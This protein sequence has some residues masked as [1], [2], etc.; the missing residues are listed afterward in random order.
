L[1]LTPLPAQWAVEQVLSATIMME[2]LDRFS[3]HSITV[4]G[5]FRQNLALVSQQLGIC[6]VQ[7]IDSDVGTIAYGILDDPEDQITAEDQHTITLTLPNITE[8]LR[9]ATTGQGFVAGYLP[10]PGSV[11][12]PH[13]VTSP[14]G[15]SLDQIV[16]RIGQQRWGWQAHCVAPFGQSAYV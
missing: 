13:G 2:E 14:A 9:Y 6:A 15:L 11:P 16:Q 7:I 4:S 5:S 8:D 3:P 10:P 1:D 12:P